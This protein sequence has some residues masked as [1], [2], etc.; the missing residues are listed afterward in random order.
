MKKLAINHICKHCGSVVEKEFKVEIRADMPM[1]GVG[2]DYNYFS[3]LSKTK[4]AAE[5][6]GISE[7]NYVLLVRYGYLI[8]R[9]FAFPSW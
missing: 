4:E 1:P 2:C 5:E 8:K 6:L 3:A 9:V 7:D